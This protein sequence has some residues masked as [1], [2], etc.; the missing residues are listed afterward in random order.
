MPNGSTTNI[1]LPYPLTSL[2][3]SGFSFDAA[4]WGATVGR[5]PPA[6]STEFESQTEKQPTYERRI[7]QPR[8]K[9]GTSSLHAC[10][11]MLRSQFHAEVS[12]CVVAFFL[13][14]LI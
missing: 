9:S 6:V 8:S 3:V 4:T 14:C 2:S 12:N 11:A 7:T 5:V 13:F 10:K 1:Q